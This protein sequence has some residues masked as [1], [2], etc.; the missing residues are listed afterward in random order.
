MHTSAVTC[1][2]RLGDICRG[3]RVLARRR[4]PTKG[5][6]SH[7]LHISDME[8]DHRAS[9]IG[10]RQVALAKAYTHQPWRVRIGVDQR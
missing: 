5:I 9:D 7:G 1:P 3:L 6:I 4:R 2:H 8:C 10:Q